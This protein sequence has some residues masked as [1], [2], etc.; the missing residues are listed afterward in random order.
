MNKKTSTST[1]L[2]GRQTADAE[3]IGALGYAENSIETST[4]YITNF[5]KNQE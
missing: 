1:T 5:D 4:N 3:K 2:R